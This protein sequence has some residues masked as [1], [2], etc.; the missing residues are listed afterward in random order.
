MKTVIIDDEFVQLE[1]LK[2]KLIKECSEI[3]SI[4][5]FSDP[6]DGL[7]FLSK[8]K[9]DL[10]F[11]DIE[12]PSMSGF[13]FI[14]IA[15][16]D[17][18]PP[19]IFT[20]AFS[21]Y[22]VN[23]FKVNAIDYLL[24]PIVN[25]ELKM[26]IQ[27][28]RLRKS[29]PQKLEVLIESQ[30]DFVEDRLVVMDGNSHIFVKF[31][32][33]ICLQGSGSYAFFFLTNGKKI[34]ASKRLNFYWKRLESNHFIRSHQSHVVNLKHILSYSNIGNG[35]LSLTGG[36]TVPVSKRLRSSIKAQLGLV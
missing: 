36:H 27:K 6:K 7:L 18:L 30:H 34:T 21:K 4:E 12:M 15:G 25:K 19:I 29:Q 2:Q 23:A 13:E 20:T 3:D 8:N 1:H 26:A 11:L 10:L 35:E 5:T 14:E 22:A 24:K 17:K 16:L 9:I 33:I 28:V 31:D 32:E